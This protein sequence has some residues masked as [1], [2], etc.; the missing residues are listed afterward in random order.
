MQ[1]QVQEAQLRASNK[2]VLSVNVPVQAYC[3]VPVPGFKGATMGACFVRVVDL[4]EQLQD[5]VDVNPRAPKK[6]KAGALAGPVVK[7]ILQTLT[8]EP[9]EMALRNRGLFVLADSVNYFNGHLKFR[10]DDKGKH[11]VCDGYHSLACIL[12]VRE[13]ADTPEKVR[14]LEAAYVKLTIVE[15]LAAAQV[16]EIASGLNTSKAVDDASLLNLRGEFDSIRRI[17][18]R[19]AA[20]NSIS[21]MQGDEGP[22]YI[23]SILGYLA[24]ID[25]ERFSGSSQPAGLYN[26]KGTAIRY[27]T[28]DLRDRSHNL[29]AR[30]ELLPDL[31]ELVDHIQLAIPEAAKRVGFKIG[32]GKIGHERIGSAAQR[33]RPLPFTGLVSNYKIPEAWILP[34]FAAFR[35]ALK[36]ARDGGLKW[37]A[38]PLVILQDVS[39]DLAA[40][41]LAAHKASGGHADKVGK[42]EATY[43]ACL[44]RVELWLAKKGLL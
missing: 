37:K 2:K 7:D 16:V 30:I 34:V 21:Y 33:G 8:E 14:A 26:R 10:L 12:E 22:V 5:Y 20:E 23:S 11:G 27:F 35:V 44:S 19:T 40:I 6:S 13:S 3:Q 9:Q 29:E 24:A 36:A 41:L 39:Q 15:G 17:L 42:N 43:S 4:P 32:M 1:T 38:R 25:G 18:H 28:E 31:L